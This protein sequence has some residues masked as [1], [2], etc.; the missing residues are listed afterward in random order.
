MKIVMKVL[1]LLLISASSIAAT[2]A[3]DEVKMRH[4]L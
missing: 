3:A 4:A 2:A 1:S